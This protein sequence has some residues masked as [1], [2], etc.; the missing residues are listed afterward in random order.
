MAV[1]VSPACPD[2]LVFGQDQ[3]AQPALFLCVDTQPIMCCPLAA[4]RAP[5]VWTWGICRRQKLTPSDLPPTPHLYALTLCLQLA[6]KCADLGHLSSPRVV[7]KKWV[8]YLEEEFFRQGDSE[9]KNQLA[10]SPLM[11]REKNG[12]TKSQVREGMWEGVWGAGF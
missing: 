3:R 8:Q 12:I 10:V 9:K 11:D 1:D 2:L 4:A 6:L 7:H 5:S